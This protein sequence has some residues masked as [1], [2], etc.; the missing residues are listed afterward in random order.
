MT[1]SF[2]KLC[3]LQ[4]RIS[5]SDCDNLG[6]TELKSSTNLNFNIVVNTETTLLLHKTQP[7]NTDCSRQ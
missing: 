6:N 2:T 5:C 3:E 4:R 7:D 1:A